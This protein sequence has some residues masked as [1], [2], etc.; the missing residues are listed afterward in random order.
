MVSKSPRAIEVLAELYGS[1]E[2][3]RELRVAREVVVRNRLFEPIESLIVTGVP[4]AQ[5]V[6]ESEAL[7]EVDHQLDVLAN[8]AAH[9][10]DGGEVV[11][12]SSRPRRSFNP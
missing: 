2:L 9:R 5:R 3:A 12:Q 6:A 4:P 10:F 1:L 7:V 8:G 11:S